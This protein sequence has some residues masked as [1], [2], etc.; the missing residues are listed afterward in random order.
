MNESEKMRDVREDVV[1]A[2][3]HACKWIENTFVKGPSAKELSALPEVIAA[4]AEL[5]R[6][7][8]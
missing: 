5:L 1:V 8:R 4:T 3:A 2:V 6:S 7:A